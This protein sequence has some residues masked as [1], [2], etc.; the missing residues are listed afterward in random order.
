MEWEAEPDAAGFYL[1]M[2]AQHLGTT[3]SRSGRTLPVMEIATG[4]QRMSADAPA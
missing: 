4:A 2:G 3:I 1:R